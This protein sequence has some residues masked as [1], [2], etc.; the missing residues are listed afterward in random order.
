VITLTTTVDDAFLPR[1]AGLLDHTPVVLHGQ[2][3]A[4]NMLDIGAAHCLCYDIGV[5]A[6]K[7]KDDIVALRRTGIKEVRAQRFFY[8]LYDAVEAHRRGSLDYTKGCM[9]EMQREIDS[10]RQ[11][12]AKYEEPSLPMA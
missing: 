11:S 7:I 4:A 9:V 1:V 10:L 3:C 12:L 6:E 5:A 2:L 8:M